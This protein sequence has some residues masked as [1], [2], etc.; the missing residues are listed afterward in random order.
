V[1]SSAFHPESATLPLRRFECLS[2]R[3][4]DRLAERLATLAQKVGDPWR[5]HDLSA[6]ASGRQ[7]ACDE[8]AF[9]GCIEIIVRPSQPRDGRKDPQVLDQS[10]DAIGGFIRSLHEIP[11]GHPLRLPVPVPPR[12]RKC[13]SVPIGR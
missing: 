4:H 10:T 6:G 3:A 8:D 5:E 9:G 13:R 2:H 12:T 1:S 11:G 7:P